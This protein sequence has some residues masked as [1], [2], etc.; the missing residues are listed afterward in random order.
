MP[1]QI[2]GDNVWLLKEVCVH[3]NNANLLVNESWYILSIRLR[4]YS[5]QKV[6]HLRDTFDAETESLCSIII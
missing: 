1:W 2:A 4:L 5:N 3:Y 6:S